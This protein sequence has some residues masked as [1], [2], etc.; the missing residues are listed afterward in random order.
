MPHTQRDT[1]IARLHEK[2][3]RHIAHAH[4]QT[5][6]NTTHTDTHTDTPL[7]H[8][9]ITP[10]TYKHTQTDSNNNIIINAYF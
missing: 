4:T 8:T 5:Y 7:R 9:H 10:I 1:H 6:K 2:M 3:H